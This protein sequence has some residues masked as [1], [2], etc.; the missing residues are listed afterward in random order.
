MRGPEQLERVGS[1]A[2]VESPHEQ[3]ISGF[4]ARGKLSVTGQSA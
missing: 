1:D 2:A 4:H 3:D